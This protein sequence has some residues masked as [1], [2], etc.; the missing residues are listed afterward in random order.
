MKVGKND[1][2]GDRNKEDDLEEYLTNKT[3]RSH[4]GRDE[5]FPEEKESE[6]DELVYV[7]GDDDFKSHT[8]FET[9][10]GVTGGMVFKAIWEYISCFDHDGQ[11][12]ITPAVSDEKFVMKFVLDMDGKV[13]DEET[14]HSIKCKVTLSGIDFDEESVPESLGVLFE[15]KDGNSQAFRLFY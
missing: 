2:A 4:K 15:R 6:W 5:E 7:Q 13:L 1:Y 8:H 3:C 11:E 14:K 12:G 10:K 9:E